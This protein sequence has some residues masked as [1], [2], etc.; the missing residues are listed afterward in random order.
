M[1]VNVAYQRISSEHDASLTACTRS[2]YDKCYHRQFNH[3]L[4][5]HAWSA[6]T[7]THKH[8]LTLAELVVNVACQRISSVHDAC[9]TAC[10][11][12][13]Y[14]QCYSSQFNHRLFNHVWSEHWLTNT[15]RLPGAIGCSVD[16]DIVSRCIHVKYMQITYVCS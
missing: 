10:T 4:F 12:S 11:R 3:R 9:W 2:E 7:Q 14:D 13:E 16:A 6:S 15:R 1:V 5:I 8:W